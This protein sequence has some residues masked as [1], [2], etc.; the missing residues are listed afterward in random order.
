MNQKPEFRKIKAKKRLTKSSVRNYSIV[1]DSKYINRESGKESIHQVYVV[2]MFEQSI[3]LVQFVDRKIDYG[4]EGFWVV[5]NGFS[6]EQY[7]SKILKAYKFNLPVSNE[8][9]PLKK[10]PLEILENMKNLPVYDLEAVFVKLRASGYLPLLQKLTQSS[11]DLK[12]SL[13]TL[14]KSFQDL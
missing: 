6:M 7:L 11:L 1:I 3:F 4:I 14:R 5:R 2:R 13:S 12:L 9:R 10:I 8:F